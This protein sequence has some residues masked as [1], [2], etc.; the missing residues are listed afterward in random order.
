MNLPT[1]IPLQ[2]VVM[3]QVAAEGQSDKVV[4]DMEACMKQRCVTEYFHAEK[5]WH[6]ADTHQHLLN[7]YGD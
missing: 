2:V 4:T 3:W 5:K 1:N 6:T 7:I